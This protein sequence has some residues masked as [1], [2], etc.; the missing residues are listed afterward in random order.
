MPK[1]GGA[2]AVNGS[3]SIDWEDA[4]RHVNLI[5]QQMQQQLAAHADREELIGE[6]MVGLMKAARRFDPERNLK[7][8]TFAEHRIRGAMLDYVRRLDPLPRGARHRWRKA[9]E[10]I[11]KL[12][13]QLQREPEAEEIAAALGIPGEEW[14]QLAAL[15][16]RAAPVAEQRPRGCQRPPL[17]D[18]LASGGTPE[19]SAAR[20]EL[21]DFLRCA[22]RLLPDRERR[23]LHLRYFEEQTLEEIA[24]RLGCHPSRVSQLQAGAIG[25]LRLHWQRI[26]AKTK[27]ARATS[28]RQRAAHSQ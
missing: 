1:N 4:L 27:A 11:G 16:E 9:N 26:N 18:P 28:A 8:R 3:P 10:I 23:V 13:Q 15:V 17:Q 7:F 5:A 2:C 19:D 6:G 22:F 21:D 24:R 14:Y 12:R 25:L 20:A